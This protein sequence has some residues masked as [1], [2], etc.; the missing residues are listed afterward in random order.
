MKLLI[1]LAAA[2]LL[3]PS[4]Y[5][6]S[7]IL[8]EMGGLP[9]AN[10][11]VPGPEAVS[12]QFPP[13]VMPD[14]IEGSM[15]P[16]PAMLPADGCRAQFMEMAKAYKGMPYVRGG[17]SRGDGGVDCSGLVV[18]ALNDL[19]GSGKADCPKDMDLLNKLVTARDTYK[20]VAALPMIR[21]EELK[22]GDLV[23]SDYGYQGVPGPGHVFIFIEF[24]GK[25]K[26]R[27][28]ESGGTG[29]HN[30]AEEI[31]SIQPGA[32]FGSM[33]RILGE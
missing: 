33:S 16:A 15:P 7:G 25:D 24:D 29:D 26:A 20:M 4:V 8:D 9:E 19:R 12:A 17:K 31:R 27:V 21:R 5:A 6:N 32:T 11:N 3:T 30:V 13:E 18:A 1:L 2:A 28:M 14:G 23:F 10:L 22:M